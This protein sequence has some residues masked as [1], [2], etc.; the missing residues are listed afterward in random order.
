MQRWD[1]IKWVFWGFDPF[2]W[3]IFHLGIESHFSLNSCTK[4]LTEKKVCYVSSK[5]KNTVKLKDLTFIKVLFAHTAAFGWVLQGK[6]L[7]LL[8]KIR[9]SR[10]TLFANVKYPGS[11]RQLTLVLNAIRECMWS[12]HKRLWHHLQSIHCM[13]LDG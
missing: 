1:T 4:L 9:T 8:G 3:T 6:W 11:F 13:W 7:Y 5:P 12:P 10:K 2:C